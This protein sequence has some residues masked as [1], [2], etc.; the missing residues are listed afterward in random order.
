MADKKVTELS[1]T[2]SMDDADL[3]MSVDVTGPTS[4]KLTWA[5]VKS[6]LKTY[7]DTLY[8][9]YTLETHASNHTDGTDDI[10]NATS[11]QKGVATSTQIT[12]F[13]SY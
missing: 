12:K 13:N 8:N 2:T 1:A 7:F 3:L 4:K 6:I 10:Q 5:Y 11:S 9:K